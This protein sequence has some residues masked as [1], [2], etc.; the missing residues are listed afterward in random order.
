MSYEA[1]ACLQNPRRPSSLTCASCLFEDL[2]TSTNFTRTRWL[3][4]S[5]EPLISP[6]HSASLPEKSNLKTNKWIVERAENLLIIK[7][8]VFSNTF[9]LWAASNPLWSFEIAFWFFTCDR[10]GTKGKGSFSHSAQYNIAFNGASMR[11]VCCW[12]RISF[13]SFHKKE[14][15]QTA[16]PS[17]ISF[18]NNWIKLEGRIVNRRDVWKGVKKRSLLSLMELLGQC[19]NY[20]L[21]FSSV[22][23]LSPFVIHEIYEWSEIPRQQQKIFRKMQ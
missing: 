6:W 5:F 21:I 8:E 15:L 12:W 18:F 7:L 2:P 14:S 22:L 16:D 19:S 11:F 23:R 13:R 4:L 20:T 9:S 3:L 17:N 1:S 10:R